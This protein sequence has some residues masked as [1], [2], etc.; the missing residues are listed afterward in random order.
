MKMDPSA[1]CPKACRPVLM[2]TV[3]GLAMF[4]GPVSGQA[5]VRGT[6]LV[7]YNVVA[8]GIPLSLTGRAGDAQAGRQLV[9]TRQTSMCLLC[10]TGPLPEEPFPGNLAP[11]L[12]GTGQRWTTAQ[13]R[14]RL[15]DSSRLN[16]D[17]IMPSYHRTESLTRVGGA[18]RNLPIL[19]T[20]QIEDVV[21][22]LA[23]L[24]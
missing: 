18:W 4:A 5:D 13:L 10:H 20:Q 21:A 23:T 15:V 19:S 7:P 9:A 3:M 24:R 2:S 11:D 8:D 14:L 1:P 22:F 17:T 6:G 12:S 16:P